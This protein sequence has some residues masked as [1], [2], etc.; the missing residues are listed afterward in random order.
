MRV[1]CITALLLAVGTILPAMAA[2]EKKPEA[3][4]AAPAVAALSITCKAYRE[5]AL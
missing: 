5:L 1:L 4:Q 2:D 3:A